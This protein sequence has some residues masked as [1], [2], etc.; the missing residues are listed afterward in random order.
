MVCVLTGPLG[1]TR[2]GE[3]QRLPELQWEA[4]L[5][6][7]SRLQGEVGAEDGGCVAKALA[8]WRF[9]QVLEG[10]GGSPGNRSR[11]QHKMPDQRK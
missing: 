1:D 7:A 8:L 11:T 6:R 3:P 4:E 2:A 10:R 5:M 9:R